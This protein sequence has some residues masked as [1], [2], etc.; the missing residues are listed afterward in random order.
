MASSKGRGAWRWSWVPGAAFCIAGALVIGFGLR[1]I[2]ELRATRSWPTTQGSVIKSDP[3]A[4]YVYGYTL[5]GL[6]YESEWVRPAQAAA[7]DVGAP[8]TV[9]YNPSDPSDGHLEAGVS[10]A[11]GTSLWLT[12]A[13]GGL[14]LLVGIV[15]L[16]RSFTWLTAFGKPR[17]LGQ[18][19]D[20]FRAQ[21][22]LK[23]IQRCSKPLARPTWDGDE[24]SMRTTSSSTPR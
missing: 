18:R 21:G 12:P 11:N 10:F 16:S 13:W 6:T 23:A 22:I 3:T 4:G 1:R 5:E 14:F 24:S 7:K 2:V 15:L 17:I 8:V 9:R 19:A 20:P